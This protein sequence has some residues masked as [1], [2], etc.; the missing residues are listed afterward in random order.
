MGG[1]ELIRE[2]SQRRLLVTT[3]VMTAF[4][5]IEGAVE[6]VG[7][8][9]VAD[10]ATAGT[11]RGASGGQRDLALEQIAVMTGVQPQGVHHADYSARR[12]R[13]ATKAPHPRVA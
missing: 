13:G 7:L 9:P 11:A 1:M 4:G 12:S 6:A 2:V 5:T 3:I 10:G 8:A